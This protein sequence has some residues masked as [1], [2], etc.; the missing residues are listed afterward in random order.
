MTQRLTTVFLVVALL[1]CALLGLMRHGH[2]HYSDEW[3][4]LSPEMRSWFRGLHAPLGAPCC[5]DADGHHVADVD[6]ESQCATIAGQEQ[7]HFRVR[8]AKEW[9]DVPDKAVIHDPNR[10]GQAVVWPAMNPASPDGYFRDA[11]GHILIRCFIAG[12]GI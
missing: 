10:Y 7:C 8:L 5:D 4:D 9:V 6:W 2:A 1:L 3:K 12:A 11:K